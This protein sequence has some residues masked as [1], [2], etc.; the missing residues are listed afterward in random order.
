MRRV[1]AGEAKRLGT[2]AAHP[3]LAERDVR[4]HVCNRIVDE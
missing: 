4:K 1:Q 2:A 3:T